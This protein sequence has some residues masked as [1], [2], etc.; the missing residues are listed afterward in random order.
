MGKIAQGCS[1]EYKQKGRTNFLVKR[2]D[3]VVVTLSLLLGKISQKKLSSSNF[4]IIV[5][6]NKLVKIFAKG[7]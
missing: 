1:T 6:S 2:E 4:S 5:Q 3:H 7:G